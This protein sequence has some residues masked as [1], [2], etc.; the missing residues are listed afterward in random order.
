M[1][2][3]RFSYFFAWWSINTFQ[4][5]Y[6]FIVRPR[7]SRCPP[8]IHGGHAPVNH[9]TPVMNLVKCLSLLRFAIRVAHCFVEALADMLLSVQRE[10]LPYL[11]QFSI[12]QLLATKGNQHLTCNYWRLSKDIFIFLEFPSDI[13]YNYEQ[14][15]SRRF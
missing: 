15:E 5:L 13:N 11:Q 10:L 1:H 7:W 9:G 4:R 14:C 6:A 8:F 3:R 2:R 12:N